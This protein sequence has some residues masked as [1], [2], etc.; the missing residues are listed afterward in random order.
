[1]AEV[2]TKRSRDAAELQTTE[3][4]PEIDVPKKLKQDPG[5]AEQEKEAEELTRQD[6]ERQPDQME[7]VVAGDAAYGAGNEG[8][9]E[10]AGPLQG[11]DAAESGHAE[12]AGALQGGDV[13][14]NGHAEEPKQ[15][16]DE[17]KKIG[18]KTFDNGQ[19]AYKYYK[20][21][22]RELTQ[23]QDLNEYEHHMVLDLL[24]QGHP[25]ADQKDGGCLRAIQVRKHATIENSVCFHLMRSDGTLEDFSVNKCLTT[26]YPAWAQSRAAK[27]EEAKETA[28]HKGP[29]RGGRGRGRGRGRRGGRGRGRR[30]RQ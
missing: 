22:L 15:D 3:E 20:M 23:N 13:A 30:G 11:G 6:E 28:Q 26:L 8:A 7:D 1:M 27:L 12:E 14:E 16:A 2:G 17:P 19:A 5:S 18:Y 4:S 9:A 10:E 25:N 29:G 21:L 24:K